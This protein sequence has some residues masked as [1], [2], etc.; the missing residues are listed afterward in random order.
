MARLNKVALITGAS[1]K[2]GIHVI[3]LLQDYCHDVIVHYNKNH[4]NL[5]RIDQFKADFTD[6]AEVGEMMNAIYEK[7][8]NIDVLINMASIFDEDNIQNF[9]HDEL[10]NNFAIHAISPLNIIHFI[11]KYNKSDCNV[12]NILDDMINHDTKYHLSYI[13]SK[14]SL[15]NITKLLSSGYKTEKIRINAIFSKIMYDLYPAQDEIHKLSEDK[16]KSYLNVINKISMLIQ[17]K[18]ANGL[19][20]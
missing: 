12:I 15:L 16:K 17:D 7:Y 20:L 8:D 4:L 19:I 11:D 18:N 13:L 2:F 9:D 5:D 3:K 1:G 14:I 10:S 6:H